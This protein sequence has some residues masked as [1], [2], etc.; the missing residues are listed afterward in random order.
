[1]KTFQIYR[2]DIDKVL[3][4]IEAKDEADAFGQ[5]AGFSMLMEFIPFNGGY[6][7]LGENKFAVTPVKAKPFTAEVRAA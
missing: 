4:T 2:A 3:L 5:W 6:E 1:M 7:Y